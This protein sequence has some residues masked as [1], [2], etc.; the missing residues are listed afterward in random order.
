MAIAQA[1]SAPFPSAKHSHF[2]TAVEYLTKNKINVRETWAFYCQRCTRTLDIRSIQCVESMNS[3]LADFGSKESLSGLMSEVH[4]R[5]E[6]SR[7]S[8][9]IK[10]S[11][12]A[13]VGF[14]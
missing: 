10:V 14:T 13:E 4:S 8:A 7:E 6:R 5:L 3:F 2:P 1:L 12:N 9:K 11:K